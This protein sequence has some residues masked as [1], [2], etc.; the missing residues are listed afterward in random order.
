MTRPALRIAALFVIAACAH[1]S[2]EPTKPQAVFNFTPAAG[3]GMIVMYR[4]IA[5]FMGGGG[6]VNATVTC[7]GKALG[8]LGQDKYSTVEVAPGEHTVKLEGASGVSNAI[9]TLAAGEVHF[10]QVVTY[11]T[12]SSAT[13]AQGEALKDLDNEGE[14]LTEGFKYS[15]TGQPGSPAAPNTTRL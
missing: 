2:A 15:F 9:V 8:D 7:D 13:R 12:L 11:P 4:N 5:G 1:R 14:A 10:I 6:G 3:S